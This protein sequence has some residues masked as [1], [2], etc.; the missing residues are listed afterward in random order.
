MG[1]R[2]SS[3]DYIFFKTQFFNIIIHQIPSSIK[4]HNIDD[5]MNISMD[6]SLII[7][8]LPDYKSNNN[9]LYLISIIH[10]FHI[11]EKFIYN[12]LINN[13]IIDSEYI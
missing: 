6:Y 4:I 9:K 3:I 8:F 5:K 12:I 1:Y 7:I 11:I 10:E 2:I 13:N